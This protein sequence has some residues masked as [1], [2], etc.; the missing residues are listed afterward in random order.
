MYHVVPWFTLHSC[1][2]RSFSLMS[3]QSHPIAQ[4]FQL[5]LLGDFDMGVPKGADPCYPNQR[6][7]QHSKGT[8]NHRKGR[9]IGIYWW[10][11]ALLWV[12][13]AVRF[14]ESFR[15]CANFAIKNQGFLIAA[16]PKDSHAFAC[17]SFLKTGCE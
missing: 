1:G 16:A 2:G 13:E 4:R 11:N 3:R 14:I 10:G 15:F 6:F 17:S 5:A 7:G 12:S 9:K 8:K